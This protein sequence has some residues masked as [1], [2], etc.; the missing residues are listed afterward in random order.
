MEAYLTFNNHVLK[1]NFYQPTKVALSFRIDPKFLPTYE[2]PQPLFGMFL[3][4]GAEFRGFHLRFRN[5][6]RG[7]IRV[8]KSRNREAYS[9]NLRSLFDENYSLASTQQKKNKVHI[10][11]AMLSV[12]YT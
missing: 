10:Y 5:V 12:G 9:I 8:I 11:Q 2:Y 3:V 6:A 1:T 7:G 4:I